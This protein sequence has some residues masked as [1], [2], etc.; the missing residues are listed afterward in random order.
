[1]HV[2]GETR[3]G[4]KRVRSFYFVEANALASVPGRESSIR[5]RCG[6]KGEWYQTIVRFERLNLLFD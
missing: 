1:M 6:F 2:Q 3:A 4:T 5:T